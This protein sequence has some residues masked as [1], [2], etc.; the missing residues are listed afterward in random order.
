[1]IDLTMVGLEK[2]R[3]QVKTGLKV[4]HL[5]LAQKQAC[6]LDQLGL[7]AVG[8]G[9]GRSFKRRRI[10]GFHFHKDHDLLIAADEI[11]FPVPAS[12]IYTDHF[13]AL[14]YQKGPGHFFT[15]PTMP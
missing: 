8:Q 9:L 4:P 5:V 2:D 6:R 7:F 11:Q 12:P 14:T 15:A 10:S 3:N 1:M 13:I